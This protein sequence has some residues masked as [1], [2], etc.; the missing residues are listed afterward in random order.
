MAANI[1]PSIWR[2]E[3]THYWALA[4]WETGFELASTLIMWGN[5]ALGPYSAAPLS[6]LRKIP[7][8]M[9]VY[10]AHIRNHTEKTSKEYGASGVASMKNE[11]PRNP[12]VDSS[13]R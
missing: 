6:L 8:C 11:E 1:C 5:M 2:Q 9:A 12:C 3:R 7:V 4:L 10:E 13:T